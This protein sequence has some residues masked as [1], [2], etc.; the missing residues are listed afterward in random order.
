MKKI[1][2]IVIS[3]VLLAGA[4]LYIYLGG[5]NSVEISVEEINGYQIAG[6]E[7]KGNADAKEIEDYFFEA[8]EFAISGELKGVL[9]I[10]HYNDTTLAK[11]ETRLFIG[12]T[13]DE[14]SGFLP[15]DY[16]LLNIN[17]D[18]VVRATIEAHNAV[19]PGPTSIE[20]RISQKAK[21]E[22]LSTELFTVEKYVSAN[23]L[24][25]DSPVKSN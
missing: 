3:V 2:L 17:C 1:F 7:F 22:G 4:G 21:E 14:Y 23:V 19:I 24:E 11:K 18:K 10:V 25:I 12:V 6:R 15:A 5:L 9:T 8:K 13:L 20:A 16:T